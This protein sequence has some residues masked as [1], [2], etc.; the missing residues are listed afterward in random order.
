MPSVHTSPA[1]S[2]MIALILF[3]KLSVEI[4]I[5]KINVRDNAW[6]TGLNKHAMPSIN[7]ARNNLSVG[8]LSGSSRL[9]LQKNGL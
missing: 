1:V 3:F 9:F 7:P 4:S 8:C 5:M 6:P 2:A